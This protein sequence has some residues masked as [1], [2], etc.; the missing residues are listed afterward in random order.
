MADGQRTSSADGTTD[1]KND[2]DTSNAKAQRTAVTAEERAAAWDASG[3]ATQQQPAD[4]PL[5]DEQIEAKLSYADIQRRKSRPRFWLLFLVSLLVA[6]IAPYGIGRWLALNRTDRLVT[7]LSSID[8][9]GIALLSWSVAVFCM[10]SLFMAFL[11]NMRVKW[12]AAFLVF[13]G[14]VQFISGFCLLKT[15]FWFSTYAVYGSAAGAANAANV[16]ILAA[17]VGLAVFAV[18]YVVILIAVKKTSPLNVLTEDWAALIM[19]WTIEVAALLI[20]IFSILRMF[21]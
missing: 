10:V 9:R 4:Q 14:C 7:M 21:A 6:L 19:F 18:L 3:S 5:T 15:R 8:P 16:G 11:D 1:G 13:L 20:S 2:V 12:T 17:A